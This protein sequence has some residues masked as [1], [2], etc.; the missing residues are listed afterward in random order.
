MKK[1][2]FVK[3]S[4]YMMGFGLFV[5]VLFPF[6][7]VLLGGSPDTTYRFSFIFV[8][9]VA[10]LVVG[11]VN[12]LFARLFIERKISKL[13][14]YMNSVNEKLSSSTI[15]KNDLE[16]DHEECMVCDDSTDKIGESTRA[17]NSLLDTLCLQ[18][19]KNKRIRDFSNL[20]NSDLE[21]NTITNKALR[22][23][24]DSI[25]AKGGALAVEEKGELNL[26]ATYHMINAEQIL[27]SKIPWETLKNSKRQYLHIP[28]HVKID[29]LLATYRP[30]HTLVEPIIYKDILLGIIILSN[31]TAFEDSGL[32]H[33]EMLIN[34]LGMAINNSLAHEQ[35]TRLAAKDPLTNLYN[36]RYGLKRMKEEYSRS[37]RNKIPLG[38][39]MLDIDHFKKV[40]DTYGHLVGDKVLSEMAL[41]LQ[42]SLREGDIAIRYGGEE[43]LVLL[44]GAAEKD[45]IILAERVRRIIEEL[46]VTHTSQQ[47]KF[48]ISVGVTS[49]PHCDASSIEDLVACADK[50]LY[51]A[52]QNGRNRVIYLNK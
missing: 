7:V 38:V 1:N 39:A 22:Q 10:G 8:S 47:I 45:C 36:R 37:L 13:S 41:A 24:I 28:E 51:A 48:T 4:V 23:L 35:L 26:I 30:S 20:L 18:L 42:E 43:F 46:V 15:L 49:F 9:I 11:V 50:A 25:G 21:L 3:L 31:D 16:A 19:N 5:G 34:N 14:V 44:P 27:E 17:F 52:K 40:N 6:I 12:I 33:I 32:E 29:G 2:I